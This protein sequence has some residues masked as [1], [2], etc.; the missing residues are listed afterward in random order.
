MFQI[1]RVA[2]ARGLPEAQ[3]RRLVEGNTTARVLGIVGEPHI[4]V[5]RLNLALDKLA[6]KS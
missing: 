6:K 4:N 1:P 5:L 3:L 2:A